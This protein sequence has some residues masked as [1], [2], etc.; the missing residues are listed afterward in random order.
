HAPEIR[1]AVAERHDFLAPVQLSA[2]AAGE[3]KRLSWPRV[4]NATGYFIAAF[5]GKQGSNDIVMWTSSE[6]QETGGALLDYVPPGEVARL[7]KER[8]VLAPERSDCA[9][10]AE[11][12]K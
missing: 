10:S 4:P 9:V 5:G 6:V 12:L 2:A 11:A 1:F 3:A 7:I 8:V